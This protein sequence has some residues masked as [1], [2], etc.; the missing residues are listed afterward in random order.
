MLHPPSHQNRKAPHW[1]FLLTPKTAYS[2]PS[3]K[4]DERLS[5]PDMFSPIGVM[6]VIAQ[7][8]RW[9]QGQRYLSEWHNPQNRYSLPPFSHLRI[10]KY[11]TWLRIE[12]WRAD[13]ILKEEL[14]CL[15][16]H[17]TCG[18]RNVHFRYLIRVMI[19]D[20]GMHVPWYLWI[21]E[22]TLSSTNFDF[23]RHTQSTKKSFLISCLSV[24]YAI[25]GHSID[26]KSH[27]STMHNPQT[28]EE[29][30]HIPRS[31]KNPESSHVTCWWS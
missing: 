16:C 22:C 8:G 14:P 29:S 19:L 1:T 20:Q 4:T 31:V 21:K 6:V 12:R 28:R 26:E 5:L 7:H 27:T 10:L 24:L 2:G 9:K 30:T 17:D 3:R 13:T 25:L 18:S 15:M 23:Q 11:M